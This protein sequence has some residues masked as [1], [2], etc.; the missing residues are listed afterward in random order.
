MPSPLVQGRIL[1]GKVVD[2]Q[3]RNA[4][5]NRPLI[6]ISKNP[7]DSTKPVW[8]VCVT[9]E[10]TESPSEHYVAVPW[11]PG[12]PTKFSKESAALCTWVAKVNISEVQ[13]SSRP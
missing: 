4:K 2:P 9:T 13:I 6:I 7:I 8:V 11:G 10:L 5:D 12:S 3:G 1:Y